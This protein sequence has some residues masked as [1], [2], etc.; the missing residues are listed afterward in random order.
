MDDAGVRPPCGEAGGADCTEVFEG[1]VLHGAKL[2]RTIGFPTANIA[3]A[4]A[5]PLVGIY[6]ARAKVGQ[7]AWRD[8]V[9]YYGRRP[10]V[11]GGQELLEVFIFEFDQEI[12]GARLAVELVSFLRGDVT[13]PDLEAMRLQIAEDCRAARRALQTPRSVLFSRLAHSSD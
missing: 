7:E 10:T 6:A 4:V 11:D 13:F 2:G 9:A 12:Y 8:A 5:P 3:V 1:V